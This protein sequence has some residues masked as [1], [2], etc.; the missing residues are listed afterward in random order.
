MK[1]S[2]PSI[3][4]ALFLCSCSHVLTPVEVQRAVERRDRAWRESVSS[5]YDLVELAAFLQR[6]ITERK[7]WKGTDLTSAKVG[8]SW[9][10][11]G[12]SMVSGDWY[13]STPNP[14]KDEFTL[15][16]SFRREERTLNLKCVREDKSKFRLLDIETEEF[17]N[18]L[19]I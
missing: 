18:E 3:F 6:T 19:T 11:G 7:I 9:M 14:E 17:T 4:A 10:I 15:R 1:L 8:T 13:F 5:R 2:F 16:A 12:G